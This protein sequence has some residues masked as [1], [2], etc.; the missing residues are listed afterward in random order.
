MILSGTLSQRNTACHTCD[1]TT[2]IW[3]SCDVFAVL[4]SGRECGADPGAAPDQRADP[5]GGQQVGVSHLS[6]GVHDQ[7]Q[8]AAT[9][10][11]RSLPVQEQ[12]R[13]LVL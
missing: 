12:I 6:Q 10:Q 1:V 13:M 4:F 11:I 9:R 7:D 2:V 3:L 5:Q 8:C